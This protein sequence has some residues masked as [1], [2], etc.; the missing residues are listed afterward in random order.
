MS[1]TPLAPSL[2]VKAGAS[3]VTLSVTAGGEGKKRRVTLTVRPGLLP[4]L[5]WCR[6][7][8][9]VEV[10]FGEG[11][12]AGR[13]RVRSVEGAPYALR[14]GPHRGHAQS[15][16]LILPPLPGLAAG[17]HEATVCEVATI[18]SAGLIVTLP[19]WACRP[20]EPTSAASE[21]EPSPEAPSQ[22]IPFTPAPPPRA[23][24][25]GFRTEASRVPDPMVQRRLEAA[26]RPSGRL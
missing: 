22:A 6:A 14:G 16:M 13:L 3:T 2:P 12:H 19:S 15:V 24:A 9:T 7:Q 1:W 21:P 5:P 26:A 18:E 20:T 25:A 10:E 17:A 23:R 11:D 4:S 8:A